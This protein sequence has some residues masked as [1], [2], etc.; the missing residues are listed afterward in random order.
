MGKHIRP[1]DLWGIEDPLIFMFTEPFENGIC[2][3]LVHFCSEQFELYCVGKFQLVENGY[4]DGFIVGSDPIGNLP[5][6]RF[7]D[8]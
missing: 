2:L 8:I 7:L 3:F 5:R 1:I 4:W 6:M